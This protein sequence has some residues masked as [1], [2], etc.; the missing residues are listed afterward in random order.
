MKNTDAS[1]TVAIIT[2]EKINDSIFDIIIKKKPIDKFASKIKY[3]SDSP[4]Q[5]TLFLDS[6]T[7]V[8]S[9]CTSLVH[10]LDY[11]DICATPAVNDIPPRNPTNPNIILD[12]LHPY[13]SGVVLFKKSTK[14]DL[15]IKKTMNIFLNSSDDFWQD[16]TGPIQKKPD[17]PCFILGLAESDLKYYT[18]TQNWNFRPYYFTSLKGVVH[19]IHG[20]NVNYEKIYKKVNESKNLRCWNPKIQNCIL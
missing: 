17:Q 15:F 4:F 9:D 14:F 19:I 6:D 20:R 10:L 8:Y 2:D 18:L 7:R 11:F 12:N 16:R 3:L 5:K 1:A 13:N